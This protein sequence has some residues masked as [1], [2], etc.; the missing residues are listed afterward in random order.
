MGFDLCFIVLLLLFL[1]LATVKW[2]YWDGL[3]IFVFS[4]LT[5]LIS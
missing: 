4:D 1:F 5:F 2:A 3:C